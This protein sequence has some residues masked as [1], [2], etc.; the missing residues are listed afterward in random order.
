MKKLQ[1]TSQRKL[2]LGAPLQGCI[3]SSFLTKSAILQMQRQLPAVLVKNTCATYELK[4]GF[5]HPVL[6][7]VQAYLEIRLDAFLCRVHD[8]SE[9]NSY[10]ISLMT[11]SWDA[12]FSDLRRVFKLRF[13]DLNG[14]CDEYDGGLRESVLTSSLLTLRS[15]INESDRLLVN[16]SKLAINL[17]MPIGLLNTY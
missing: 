9:M 16:C 15:T 6:D 8:C 4:L 5:F 13:A 14:V 1:K 7:T 17:C 10:V 2:K 3:L 11:E 12:N